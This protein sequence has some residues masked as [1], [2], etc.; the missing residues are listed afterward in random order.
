MD[1]RLIRNFQDLEKAVLSGATDLRIANSIVCTH[2]VILPPHATLQGATDHGELPVLTFPSGD[3]LGV[4]AGNTVQD[5]CIVTCENQKAIYAAFAGKDLG[6]FTFSHLKLCGMFSFIARAGSATAEIEA[7]D[8]EVIAADA[9]ANFEQPQKFGVNPLQGAFTIYNYN[10]EP[11]SHLTVTATNISV[12]RPFAPVKGS[13]IFIAGAG[14]EG[15]W[16]TLKKLTTGAVYSNGCIPEKTATII[17]A[18][19]FIMN[20]VKAEVVENHGPTVTYGTNDMVLDNWG[21]VQHWTATAA[22]TSYGP[23]SIGFVNFGTVENF[24]LQA[25]LKTYGMGSRGYN[26][27]DGTVKNIQFESIETFGDG[28]IAVQISKEIGT[29]RV[30]KSIITHGSTGT[31]LV[32]GKNMELSAIALSVQGG[33]GAEQIR[34]GGN[35]ETHGDEVTTYKVEPGAY[36]KDLQVGGEIIATGRQSR[37]EEIG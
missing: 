33:G 11:D 35:I 24:R 15:G 7:D 12:G 36:V 10:K 22:V 8:I 25:P 1:T 4:T 20:G 9:R 16:V 13:G 21:E 23:S 5:L 14:D 18:G 30:E 27:Y 6:K 2:T 29:L 37:K 34:V 26:Q 17:A 19:V 3:G 31:S 32:K 28:S